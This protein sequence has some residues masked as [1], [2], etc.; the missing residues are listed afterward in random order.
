LESE[1]KLYPELT[2]SIDE[3]VLRQLRWIDRNLGWLGSFLFLIAVAVKVAL[4][5]NLNL[6][7]ISAVAKYTSIPDL[8]ISTISNLLPLLP[9]VILFFVYRVVVTSQSVWVL[10]TSI[11]L[12][13][14]SLAVAGV[15]DPVILFGELVVLVIAFWLNFNLYFKAKLEYREAL[16]LSRQA[17]SGLAE[18]RTQYTADLEERSNLDDLI[19]RTQ[20]SS[21]DSNVPAELRK[22][23]EENLIFL[24]RRTEERDTL[25]HEFVTKFTPVSNDFDDVSKRLLDRSPKR[26]VL[27]WQKL[28][29]RTRIYYSASLVFIVTAVITITT[30]FGV[31]S[32][33]WLPSQ[34]YRMLSS[35]TLFS[36]YELGHSNGVI[37]ILINSNREVSNIQSSKLEVVRFCTEPRSSPGRTIYQILLSSKDQPN[38]RVCIDRTPN[39]SKK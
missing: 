27:D 8:T 19:A 9:F 24:Q 33:L 34:E 21:Q 20:V 16:A 10:P 32:A 14:C 1:A 30:L 39:S 29:R 15:V 2:S 25:L 4:A 31:G 28:S 23:L 18:L 11:A 7:T 6:E 17:G 36:G 35:N 13:L 37:T 5:A 3:P 38:Y 26:R 22:Q 12:T